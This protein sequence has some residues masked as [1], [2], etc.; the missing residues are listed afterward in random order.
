MKNPKHRDS[1]YPRLSIGMPVY[2]GEKY[3]REALDS[4]LAQSFTDFELIIS[5]NA[6]S[7]GTER[8]CRDYAARDER[9]RYV[10]HAKNRGAIRNFQ[11]LLDEVHGEYFMWAAHDD[12]WDAKWAANLLPVAQSHRCLAYGYVQSIDKNG[13][14]I[15]HP[16]NFQKYEFTGSRFLR[17]CKYF[18]SPD[19]RGKANPIYG[20]MPLQ[21][22]RELGISA[23]NDVN[24]GSDMIF[25]YELLNRMEI[26]H[27]GEVFLYKRIP[28]QSFAGEIIAEHHHESI[29]S[30][31]GAVIKQAFA[32]PMLGE[33]MKRSTLPE[34]LC[35]IVCYPFCVLRSLVFAFFQKA[36]RRYLMP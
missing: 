7:D 31:A 11:F 16:A 10:R 9:V 26:R 27:G 19:F 23:L 1:P 35:L 25:L 18:L 17:R 8:I 2:N 5:D 22:L 13:G 33:Y 14:R 20:I 3:I 29:A 21:A 12:V 15:H 6:S 32:G 34:S 30:R 4:L 28:C 36:R 24:S